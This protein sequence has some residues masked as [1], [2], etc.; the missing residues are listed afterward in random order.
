MDSPLVA[1]S[2]E[3]CNQSSPNHLVDSL[4]KAL[5]PI[6]YTPEM[7]R[8]PK[9]DLCSE[10]VVKQALRTAGLQE[11]SSCTVQIQEPLKQNSHEDI[12][13]SVSPVCHLN[14]TVTLYKSN[15][16]DSDV[17]SSKDLENKSQPT[18]GSNS[19]LQRYS[20][21]FLLFW[22]YHRPQ[23]MHI[24]R[25][26]GKLSV[27]MC[28]IIWSCFSVFVESLHEHKLMYKANECWQ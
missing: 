22:I 16:E 17:P 7:C 20:F 28:M 10:T 19:V 26:S 18:N 14:S 24:P 25:Y 8:M 21:T 15:M 23:L 27:T 11:S 13:C 5:R 2:P 6:V 12:A 3:Q 9:V 4:S 1:Q